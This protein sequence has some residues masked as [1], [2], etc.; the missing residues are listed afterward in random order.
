MIKNSRSLPGEF[1][2]RLFSRARQFSKTFKYV[3]ISLWSMNS[4]RPVFECVGMCAFARRLALDRRR[5]FQEQDCRGRRQANSAQSVGHGRAGALPNGDQGYAA[6]RTSRRTC[7]TRFRP[8]SRTALPPP[9]SSRS[10]PPLP[11]Y[12]R[13]ATGIV[14]VY[15]LTDEQSFKNIEFWLSNIQMHASEEVEKILI[16]NK[17]DMFHVRRVRDFGQCLF[18][19]CFLSC[20]LVFVMYSHLNNSNAS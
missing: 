5:R 12:Y 4:P 18:G 9:P 1:I 7:F 2:L 3:N 15:D 20:S 19:I 6:R 8:H 14:L 10:P 11:A 17:T 16:A 13:G